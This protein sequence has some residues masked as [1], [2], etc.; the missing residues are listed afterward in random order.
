MHHCG[1]FARLPTTRR[2]MLRR[3]AGGF[4]NVALAALLADRAYG[5]DAPSRPAADS[6]DG[7]PPHHPPRARS[8]IFLFMEGGPSQVDTFDPK[9]RLT[10]EHGQPF[11][12]KAEPTQFNNNGKTL[13]SPWTFRPGGSCGTPVSDLFPLIR[14][15]MDDITVI[16]SMTSAFSEHAAANYFLHT[17]AGQ[18]GKPSMGSWV[19]YGL[20]S[21][22]RDLPGFVVLNSGKMPIGGPDSFNSGFLPAT[23]QGS[24]FRAGADAVAYIKPLEPEPRVQ[25]SKFTAIRELDRE[26][27][28]RFAHADALESAVANYEMA[29]RMQSAV[30]ELADL[31]AETVATRKLYG[32]DSPNAMTRQ[33][34]ESCLKARRLVERGVRF[35]EVTMPVYAGDTDSWDAHGNLKKNHTDNARA[36]DEPVAAL[37]LDLKGRGL[38]ETTLVV[39]AGEFGRTPF[40]QG[41]DGR[42]HNPFGFSIWLAGG[43]IKGGIV[44]GAT[45]EYGYKAVEGRCEIHDL[46]ATM[47]HL[48]GVDHKRL[49]YRWGG[50]DMRLTDV[51]GERINAVIA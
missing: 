8:V 7:R 43:G 21:E 18:Q 30:P 2:E 5:A 47:L 35:V 46:H 48:L 23:Y 16:R 20:G 19:S 4:G 14:N 29:F 26:V 13:A 9:P 22:C 17:G 37:L 32:L 50:R 11:K 40:A 38:L 25:R 36:V 1:R 12:M 39:F 44:H 34:G 15:Q 10:R 3:C 33:F 31:A 6:T 41:S 28:E 42:D 24:V 27:T 49:T 45:D 51:H